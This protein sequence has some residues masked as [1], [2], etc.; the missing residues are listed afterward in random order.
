MSVYIA[1]TDVNVRHLQ[2]DMLSSASAQ[3][4]MVR[5]VSQT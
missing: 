2:P 1:R 3:K 5:C 4:D